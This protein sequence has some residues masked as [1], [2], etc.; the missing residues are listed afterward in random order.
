MTQFG[1][2]THSE[3][4][5]KG[6]LTYNEVKL[7]LKLSSCYWKIVLKEVARKTDAVNV[8]QSTVML[9]FVL[10]RSPVPFPILSGCHV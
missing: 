1:M 3:E 9:G 10:E 5:Q 2:T 8:V 4:R 6:Q 7:N